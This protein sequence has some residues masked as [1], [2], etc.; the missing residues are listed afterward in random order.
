AAQIRREGFPV[1]AKL[2]AQNS[3]LIDRNAVERNNSPLADRRVRLA[4]N[5]AIDKETIAR[6]LY[7]GFAQPG[8][9][10]GLPGSLVWD[11]S[12]RPIPFD[13]AQARRLLAEAGYPNGFRI[14]GGID[15]TPAFFQQSLLL[16]VQDYWRQIG[17]EVGLNPVD[18]GTY[19][20]I[21]NARAGRTRN[22]LVMTSTGDT[23]GT[24]SGSRPTVTCNRPPEAVFWCVPRFDDLMNQAYAEPDPQR[25][26]MLAR[27]A[28]RAF[29]DEVAFIFLV[30]V[31][32]MIFTS[33]RV[34]NLQI[35]LPGLWNL[36][37]VFLSE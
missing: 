4:L 1:D 35:A 34:Q 26:A 2:S 16:A 22:E 27:Q 18:T 24:Y 17:V 37:S 20:D 19:S 14:A 10:L 5:Y 8:G 25:R 21:V 29:V 3:I 33:P 30:N 6:T 9:Q 31:P 32:Q 15:F 12:L 28:N 23:N 36:D 7:Q 13:Q 11:E